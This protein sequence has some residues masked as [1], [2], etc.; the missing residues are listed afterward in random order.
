MVFE[1]DEIIQKKVMMRSA[2]FDAVLINQKKNI[3]STPR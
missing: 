2:R 1:Q 3:F